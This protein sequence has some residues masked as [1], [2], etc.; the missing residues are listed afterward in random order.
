MKL[1][2][3]LFCILSIMY[4]PDGLF[5]Q[6]PCDPKGIT[7]NPDA[8]INSELPAYKNNFFDW[9]TEYYDVN[10][11]FMNSSQIY[12]PFSPNLNNNSNTTW[13]SLNQDFKPED[14][15][16]LI[17]WDMGF[18]ED[19][20]IVS[21]ITGN[22]HFILYNKFTS[23]IRIFVAGKDETSYN[24][25]EVILTVYGTDQIPTQ[26]SLLLDPNFISGLDKHFT[27]PLSSASNFL[28]GLES[29][30]FYADFFIAFDPCVCEY[31]SEMVFEIKMID[32]ALI[33]LSGDLIGTIA[34]VSSGS[35][36]VENGNSFSTSD[37]INGGKKAYNTY[38]SAAAFKTKQKVVFGIP[39]NLPYGMMTP[40]QQKAN[41]ALSTFQNVLNNDLLEAGMVALPFVKTALS[42]VKIFSAS[43]S[44]P[45]ESSTEPLAINTQVNLQGNIESSKTYISP[46][47]YVPGS[48]GSIQ[49][50]NK[51][52]Y[53][54]EQLGVFNLIETPTVSLNKVL[55]REVESGFHITS[56]YPYTV[57]YSFE[58]VTTQAYFIEFNEDLLKYYLNPALDISSE[59]IQILGSIFI[60]T[61]KT[62]MND[63]GL[64]KERETISVESD[65]VPLNCLFSNNFSFGSYNT[66]DTEITQV[67]G[68]T[69]GYEFS[70]LFQ[71]NWTAVNTYM[72]LNWDF[73]SPSYAP[74]GYA[75]NTNGGWVTVPLME[76][77]KEEMIINLRIY[78][79]ITRPN[80]EHTLQVL[81]YPLEVED[82]SAVTKPAFNNHPQ[83]GSPYGTNPYTLLLEDV[84]LTQDVSAFNI[85][86]GDNV[87][88]FPGTTISIIGG[89]EIIV[90]P[91]AVLDPEIILLIDNSNNNESYACYEADMMPMQTAEQVKTF[92]LSNQYADLRTKSSFSTNSPN[93]SEVVDFSLYPNPTSA[94]TN[95]SFSIETHKV[96]EIRIYDVT[97]KLLNES[98]KVSIAAGLHTIELE[99]SQYVPGYYICEL[100]IGG[101]VKTKKLIIR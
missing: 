80:G 52:P 2:Q 89:N 29:N 95:I 35:G 44:S 7:T 73:L 54:N 6:G 34:D 39:N 58:E 59:D 87:T 98:N 31:K 81:S 50:T 27:E 45:A 8:P 51:Y 74:T 3:T 21:P 56:S 48:K 61:H 64:D 19:N 16:E 30:W 24:T 100:N 41:D 43:T 62:N 11:S 92:C 82:V 94:N 47:Y 26:P 33:T 71:T 9:R 38:K 78:I 18:D 10:S 75:N 25:A 72:P 28:N 90:L 13:L 65:V 17:A 97:G 83:L 14:G 99:T 66:F 46:A 91:D 53:Y 4:L 77:F 37:L 63:T 70:N 15:W 23:I 67:N 88:A 69:E 93:E 76:D 1:Y 60:E 20:I 57:E 85:I 22:V 12:S 101:N 42:L 96:V 49:Q 68:I 5:A 40:E 84:M 55:N 32:E 86:V 79:T 36:S